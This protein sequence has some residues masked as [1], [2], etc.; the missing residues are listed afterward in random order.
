MTVVIGR[1]EESHRPIIYRSMRYLSDS[2]P[3]PLITLYKINFIFSG[4]LHKKSSYY[5]MILMR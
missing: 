4:I 1:G 2:H 3:H 5:S